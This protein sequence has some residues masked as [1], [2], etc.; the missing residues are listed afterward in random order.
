MNFM[1]TSYRL[2]TL[3]T[4]AIIEFNETTPDGIQRDVIECESG[5]QIYPPLPAYDEPLLVGEKIPDEVKNKPKKPNVNTIDTVSFEDLM[6]EN[7]TPNWLVEGLIEKSDLGLIFGSSGGGKSFV[8]LEMCYC[9]AAGIPFHGKNTKLGRV[10]YVC[11]EGYGGIQKRFKALHANHNGFLGGR[12]HLTRQSAALMDI[13]S[14]K[15]VR[16]TMDILGGIDLVVVDTLHRNFGAGDENSSKD[17]AIL[18]QNVDKCIKSSGATVIII[19]HSG[20]DSNGRS[21]GSSSIRAAMDVEFEVIKTADDIVTMTNTKMKNFE[22]PM[23]MAFKFKPIAESV[24]L[25]STEF[26]SK[27]KIKP[28]SSNCLIAL[29]CLNKVIETEGITPPKII[30][31]LFKDSPQKIPNKVVTIEQWRVS[32]YEAIP[33]DSEPAKK[34]VALRAAFHRSRKD[35][36]AAQKIGVFGSYAW[37][38]D[39]KINFDS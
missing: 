30:I 5:F 23:P 36:D 20:N 4:K 12:L 1:N 2:E 27:P 14:A 29:Q 21:R 26:V 18:L 32:A 35:L 15:A 11:G 9:I 38:I 37:R 39:T 22:P 31:D 6:S 24:I 7:Y 8:V 25:E 16:N 17:F 28:L 19:H 13:E 10:L 34:Q 3:A 33:V